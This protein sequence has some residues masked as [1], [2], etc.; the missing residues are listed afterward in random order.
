MP[1][2]DPPLWNAVAVGLWTLLGVSVLLGVWGVARRSGPLLVVAGLLSLAL[3]WTAMLSIG[4]FLLLL[5]LL[6]LAAGTG[7]LLHSRRGLY[8]ALAVAL[9][10][11]ALQLLSL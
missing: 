2:Y 1:A 10:L 6:E 8:V 11:Y 7:L 3:S 4:R 9:G 5:P